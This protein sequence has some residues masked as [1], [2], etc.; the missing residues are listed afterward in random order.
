MTL[1]RRGLLAGLGLA[2][3]AGIATAAEP[4]AA[5]PTKPTLAERLAAEAPKH[6]LAMDFDGQAWSGPGL[7]R[8]IAD[9][10]AAQFFLLGE[11]HG[12][13]QIPA[14]ARQ[15]MIALQP[16][17]YSR[18]AL[19]VSPPAGRALD[20][21]VTQ[22]LDGLRRFYT[23]NPPGAAFYTMKEE[24]RMLAD[25]RAVFP[26]HHDL[27]LGLDYEICLDRMLI[28]KLKPHAPASARPALAALEAASLAS[29]AR[30]EETKDISVIFCFSGDPA[31]VRAVWDAWVG[32]I[33]TWTILRTLEASLVINQHYSQGRFFKSNEARADFNRQSW[34]RFW[35]SQSVENRQ[36]KTL[37]K[38]G[39]GHMGRGRSM[40]EV[41]DLGSL[42][43]ETAT[44]MNAHSFHLLAAPLNGGRQAVLNPQTFGYDSA[45][46]GTIAELGLEPLAAQALPQGS[47]LFD[48]RP[49]RPLM[50]ASATLTADP[51]LARIIHGYDALLLI[52]GSTASVGL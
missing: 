11:E 9:G 26:R 16:A 21:A 14:L 28:A 47:T 38:F 51:R 17:G 7:D 42:V 34:A 8:L 3:L 33:E 1:D 50:S 19:E 23:T 13:A 5:A 45:E 32:D 12:V 41:Y 18:M 37:L 15:V 52:R 44:L 43:S 39:A 36:P 29:W 27:L 20:L 10:A 31:L 48:L 30:Y 40:M 25:V 24:A 22:G 46:T 35:E 49:L 4:P 2:G 6:R